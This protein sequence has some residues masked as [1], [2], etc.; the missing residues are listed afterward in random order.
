MYSVIIV[1]LP[2]SA[3]ASL[4]Q[5]CLP[6]ACNWARPD[7][8]IQNTWATIWQEIVQPKNHKRPTT[9]IYTFVPFFLSNFISGLEKKHFGKA[10]RKESQKTLKP[11]QF[12]ITPIKHKNK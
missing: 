6:R 7:S 4:K 8:L 11:Y 1:V 2:L 12:K 3:M 10:G 5:L 9:L